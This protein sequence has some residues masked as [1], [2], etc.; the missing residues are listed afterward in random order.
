MLYIT[1]SYENGNFAGTEEIASSYM[2]SI[3]NNNRNAYSK[4]KSRSDSPTL[5]ERIKKC[6]ISSTPGELRFKIYIEFIDKNHDIYFLI[7]LSK[8]FDRTCTFA[9]A[10]KRYSIVDRFRR[11]LNRNNR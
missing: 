7:G 8:L 5:E 3:N 6:R 10:P 1:I 9:Q 2:I 11:N 4:R